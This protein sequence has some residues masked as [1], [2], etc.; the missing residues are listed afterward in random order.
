M[1]DLKNSSVVGKLLKR[2]IREVTFNFLYSDSLWEQ[3]AFEVRSFS[4]VVT[5]SVCKWSRLLLTE[6]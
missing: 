5:R 2:P 4:T 1:D 3:F 6:A